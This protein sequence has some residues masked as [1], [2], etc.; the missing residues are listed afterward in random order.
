MPADEASATSAEDTGRDGNAREQDLLAA[1][2]Q[3]IRT[4]GEDYLR[5]PN[6]TSI[7]IGYKVTDGRRTP[8]LSVQFTVNEKRSAPDALRALGTAAVPRS[9]TVDGVEV[10]TDVLERRYEP[11]FKVV[12]EPVP[13]QRKARIDPVVPG[14]SVGNVHVSAG[15][16]GGIV[17]DRADGTPYVLSNWHVLHGPDG[18]LGDDVVQPGTHDDNRTDRNRLGRLVRSHL[19]IAGD[20]AV[21]SIEDREFDPAT[22]ELDVVPD[23]LGEPELGDTVVKSGRTTGVTHGVVRRVD[24]I[25]ELDYGGTVGVRAIGCFEIG[26]DPDQPAAALQI[27]RGGDSGSLWMFTR[28]GRTQTVVA[29]LHF[30]GE[31]DTSPDDHALACLPASVFEKLAISL[32]P[33]TVQEI[34]EP[35][36]YDRDFLGVRIDVPVPGA[37]LRDDV[38]ATVDGQQVVRH[39]HFSLQVRASRRFASWVAWNVDG[40]ALKELSRKGIKFVKDPR[41]PED[42]QVGDELYSDND[43][44]RGHLARRADLLWGSLPVAKKA[45]T[46]SFF[47]TNITPQMDDFNQSARAGVWGRLEDAVFADVDVEDLR[48]SVFGGPVFQDD[49]RVYRGVQ[50]PREYWKVLVFREGGTLRARAFLLT[51]GLDQLEALELDEFR[52]FQTAVRELEERTGLRF[53]DVLRDADTL[54]VPEAL[55][56]RAPLE[57][58]DDIRW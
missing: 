18:A 10:P 11:A 13:V 2:R 29:G 5:D 28:A 9:I 32:R 37:S 17:Y 22:I 48:I 21:A 3:F 56:R 38:A 24:T 44:D 19:G 47:F 52:V 40:G 55:D 36:G 41:I 42:L 31:S 4:K 1:L 49:D 8:E 12:P 53:P 50:L 45:N 54:T 57:G 30:G 51:Q 39:T 46:D 35:G 6:I 20:C 43:L 26:P 23:Q 16:L 58:T 34:E 7:G 14:V 27:S 33:P 15:T 25:V